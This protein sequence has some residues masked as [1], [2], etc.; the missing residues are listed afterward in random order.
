MYGKTMSEVA[1]N[2]FQ[3]IPKRVVKIRTVA[4]ALFNRCWVL[5]I[6]GALSVEVLMEY[7]LLGTSW[8]GW[9]YNMTSQTNIDGS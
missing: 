6:R 9:F 4:Q 1:P 7:L 8:M 5:D 2:L 3:T